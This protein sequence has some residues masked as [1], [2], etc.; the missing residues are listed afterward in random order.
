MSRDVATNCSA[1]T[2]TV[3]EAGDGVTTVQLMDLEEK[4]SLYLCFSCESYLRRE[5]GISD[6]SEAIDIRYDFV[7]SHGL[8][9]QIHF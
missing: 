5:L 2:S 9:T 6:L 4:C 3:I 1:A 8:T 7:F